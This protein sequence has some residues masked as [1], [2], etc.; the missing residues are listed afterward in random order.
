MSI[1][2][3][4]K[5]VCVGY[6]VVRVLVQEHMH[7]LCVCKTEDENLRRY[8]EIMWNYNNFGDINLIN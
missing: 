7:F 8:E 3:F 6:V 1:W 4:L 2:K 5:W